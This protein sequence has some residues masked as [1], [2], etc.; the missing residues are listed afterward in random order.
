MKLLPVTGRILVSARQLVRGFLLIPMTMSLIGTLLAVV[1]VSLDRTTA[2]HQISDTLVFL[3]I[4]AAGARSVLS[5]IAGAM[6]TVLSL[7]Y[8]LTLVVFTLAASNIGPRLL[9]TFTDNRVNQTT[10]GLLG[11]TFLYSLIVLYIVGD[12]EVPK[13]S[14]ALA[15][16]LSAISFFWLVYFV[17]DVAR[18][19]MVD[20]E[21]GRTQRAL[22]HSVHRLLADEPRE[23]PG[24]RDRIPDGRR[25]A[26]KA[27]RAG[28]VTAVDTSSLVEHAREIGGFIEMKV[29]PGDFV[30][31]GLPIASIIGDKAE[32][33]DHCVRHAVLLGSA[34][35]PEGDLQFGIHLSVEIAMRALSPGVN[36]SYTAVSAIDHLSGSLCTI[37]QRGAPSSIHCDADDEPRVWL[38]ILTVESIVGTALHPLRR[39]SA[40]NV[41]VSLRLVEAIGRMALIGRAEHGAILRRHLRL[42]AADN[43]RV[44][45][46]RDDRRELAGAIWAAYSRCRVRYGE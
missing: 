1:A 37:L 29:R 8:S 44:L 26:V 13:I 17:H 20:N 9:E 39:A 32:H 16:L 34:R 45:L 35:A 40:G 36:D 11:A 18:R 28:Y 30:V 14:V 41:L 21:I 43:N 19:V 3:N 5:T 25:F 12:E 6:M 24:D 10:I 33:T 38:Q 42:I 27:E 31:E 46:N 22:R 4:D 23:S 7:V 15:I 2:L